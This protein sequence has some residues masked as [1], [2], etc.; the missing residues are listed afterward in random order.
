MYASLTSGTT[1]MHHTTQLLLIEIKLFAGW[2]QTTILPNLCFLFVYLF[3][4]LWLHWGLNLGSLLPLLPLE[5]LR[6]PQSL[7]SE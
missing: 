2:Y 7:L 5:S 3:I 1:G 6:Q 4:Y